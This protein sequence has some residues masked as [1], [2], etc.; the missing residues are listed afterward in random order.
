MNSTIENRLKKLEQKLEVNQDKIKG[1][2][3]FAQ[4]CLSRIDPY[5]SEMRMPSYA[6][7]RKYMS[8]P[9]KHYTNSR[10]N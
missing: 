8:N 3:V 7:V 9:K 5:L 1:D 4:E 2:F 10:T 6:E